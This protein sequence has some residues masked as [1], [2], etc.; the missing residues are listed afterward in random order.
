MDITPLRRRYRIHWLT[1]IA[2]LVEVAAI[3]RCQ[4]IEE[5]IGVASSTFYVNCSYFGW[6][7]NHLRQIESGEISVLASSAKRPP[8]FEYT[9]YLPSLAF[10][11]VCWV[12]F[13][14]SVGSVVE[15]RLRKPKRWQ[16]SLRGLGL[17]V[18]VIGVVLTLVKQQSF[19]QD[20]ISRIGM[21]PGLAFDVLVLHHADWATIFA[22]LCGVGCIAWVLIQMALRNVGR[23]LGLFRPVPA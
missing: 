14:Y 10:N 19:I 13:V 20:E 12:L 8:T 18:A 9:W 23:L 2:L 7:A 22:I 6:P 1:W 16:F 21:S 17:L 11:C 15:V 4:S 5:P 3:V